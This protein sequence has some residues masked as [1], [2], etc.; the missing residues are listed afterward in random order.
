MVNGALSWAPLFPAH[1]HTAI[2]SI[3]DDKD[4]W[5]GHR[6]EDK[7]KNE[8][9]KWQQYHFSCDQKFPQ[10]CAKNLIHFGNNNTQ[11]GQ[12]SAWIIQNWKH[13]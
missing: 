7:A 9:N 2:G 4:G 3:R 13:C 1:T 10:F 5:S 8:A 6:E 12:Y 11:R